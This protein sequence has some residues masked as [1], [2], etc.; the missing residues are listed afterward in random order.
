[1]LKEGADL[2]HA[3]SFYGTLIASI[4][5][6]A[7]IGLSFMPFTEYYTDLLDWKEGTGEW[8]TDCGADEEEA[9]EEEESAYWKTP[10]YPKDTIVWRFKILSNIFRD[11]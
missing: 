2:S 4:L 1:M 5:D 9:A 3:L 6:L 7:L 8:E 10:L 11:P